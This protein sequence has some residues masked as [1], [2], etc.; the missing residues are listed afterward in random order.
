MCCITF[1]LK[2]LIS[3]YSKKRKLIVRQIK[4]IQDLAKKTKLIIEI[5]SFLKYNYNREIS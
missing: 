1:S 3:D 4:I 5:G 2:E